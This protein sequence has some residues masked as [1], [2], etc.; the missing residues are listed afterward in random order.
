MILN[1]IIN[2]IESFIGIY[3]ID[4]LSNKDYEHRYIYIILFTALSYLLVT[5]YDIYH[6]KIHIFNYN[7]SC[8]YYY[9]KKRD[10]TNSNIKCSKSK[11]IFKC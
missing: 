2:I 5:L 8:N 1:Q 11:N 9:R 4:K 7:T 10:T 6:I 3:F